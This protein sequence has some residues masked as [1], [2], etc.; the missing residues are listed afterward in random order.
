[1]SSRTVKIRFHRLKHEC[2]RLI[3]IIRIEST[4][5]DP[6]TTLLQF[7]DTRVLFQ[8]NNVMRC[9]LDLMCSKNQHYRCNFLRKFLSLVNRWV[10]SYGGSMEYSYSILSSPNKIEHGIIYF[11]KRALLE[12]LSFFLEN[13]ERLKFVFG[14]TIHKKCVLRHHAGTTRYSSKYCRKYRSIAKSIIM[15]FVQ[16]MF[17]FSSFSTFPRPAALRNGKVLMHL[18]HA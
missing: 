8:S 12:K 15:V 10:I 18:K 11:I 3:L 14:S 13:F 16:P 1:M 5:F 9:L 7:Y 6:T 2:P 4:A 17:L